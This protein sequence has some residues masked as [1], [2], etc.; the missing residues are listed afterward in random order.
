MEQRIKRVPNQK[1][2][3][4][5][6][7]DCNKAKLYTTINLQ[8]LDNAAKTLNSTAGLTMYIYL[9][10]NKQGYTMA[11]S[12]EAFYNWC[13]YKKVAYNSAVAELI[14]KG[15]LVRK[16]G[17]DDDV[18]EFRDYGTMEIKDTNPIAELKVDNGFRF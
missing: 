7:A 14:A 8:C 15:Y 12:P 1:L 16:Q 10:K 9:A 3:I 11:L 17:L 5:K 18:Y 13:G 2:I 6:K 4:V